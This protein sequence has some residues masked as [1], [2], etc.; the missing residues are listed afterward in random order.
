MK[1]G[2]EEKTGSKPDLANIGYTPAAKVSEP[3]T[4]EKVLAEIPGD[5]SLKQTSS[6]PL[7]FFHLLERLKTTKRE[8]WRRFG[9][10]HGES[11]ADHMYRMSIISMLAPPSLAARLD[12]GKCIKMCLVHD[13]AELIVGDITPVDGVPKP[14]K[15]RRETNTMEYLTSLLN[16]GNQCAAAGAE[17]GAIWQEYEDAETLESRFVH[18]VDKME[19]LLQMMEYER[20]AQQ[21]LDLGEF[22]YVARKMGL[23]ETRVWAEELLGERREFWGIRERVDGDLGTNGGVAEERNEQQEAYYSQS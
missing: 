23:A 12:L 9:I 16:D 1:S 17:L 19:L 18:D 22:A 3:W 21:T 6:S 15:S 10:S 7:V 5:L 4:V 20:R 8:G 11:I 13:M 14:E 2:S